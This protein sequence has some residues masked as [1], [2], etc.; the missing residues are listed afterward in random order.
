MEQL[1]AL[2]H[3]LGATG[4]VHGVVGDEV[5]PDVADRS[6]QNR[7]VAGINDFTW[8]SLSW[9]AIVTRPRRPSAASWSSTA[10][11]SS[12][13]TA[14]SLPCAG[15]E[16]RLI[17]AKAPRWTAKLLSRKTDLGRRR[18]T[19]RRSAR[20]RCGPRRRPRRGTPCRACSC[21]RGRRRARRPRRPRRDDG[22]PAPS[23]LLLGARTATTHPS[24]PARGRS[25][26]G[27][28]GGE[29][30]GRERDR[31]SVPEVG[32]VVI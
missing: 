32:C 10:F 25:G 3:V 28:K 12:S 2:E 11:S 6:T 29:W 16:S 20:R 26:S 18:R 30:S 19:P 15:T 5:M 14:L 9:F 7:T 4:G 31:L 24:S 8:R 13:S 23:W 22:S 27:R 21:R 17:S 1:G